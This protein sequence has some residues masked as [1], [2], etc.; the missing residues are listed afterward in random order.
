MRK[1]RDV[2]A[3]SQGD[4]R[5][6]EGRADLQQYL[7]W[8][9]GSCDTG[10]PWVGENVTPVRPRDNQPQG[11]R[12]HTERFHGQDKARHS[13]GRGRVRERDVCGR[14]LAYVWLCERERER[15]WGA[16]GVCGVTSGVPLGSGD[17][18]EGQLLYIV[19]QRVA[20]CRRHMV[21]PQ[22]SP[23]QQGATATFTHS[24]NVTHIQRGTGHSL[25]NTLHREPL[26][27]DQLARDCSLLAG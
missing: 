18:R 7:R 11:Q 24:G 1:G 5:G 15:G 3:R 4:T 8:K 21:V 10:L 25:V 20:S 22:A 14:A 27:F 17:R 19:V 12:R 2:N 6:Q 26:R 23:R 13:A 16:C 9:S